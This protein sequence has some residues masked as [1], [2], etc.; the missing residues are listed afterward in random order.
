MGAV[1]GAGDG[2]TEAVCYLT[3]RASTRVERGPPGSTNFPQETPTQVTD[4]HLILR[5]DRSSA[6]KPWREYQIFK[7][8]QWQNGFLTELNTIL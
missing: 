5:V 6:E 4:H 1:P 2:Q 7:C 3:C 8:F